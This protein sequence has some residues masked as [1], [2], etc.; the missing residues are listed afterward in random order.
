MNGAEQFIL[1]NFDSD[2]PIFSSCLNLIVYSYNSLS[3]VKKYSRNEILATTENIRQKAAKNIELEDYLRN[4]LV[5][6]YISPN[7]HLFGL[8]FYIFQS[9]AEEFTQNIKTGVLD[10]KVCSPL[11]DGDIY[12]IFE[13]KRLNKK[14]LSKY[15]DEG[16]LRF[17]NNQYYSE[18]D[19]NIGGMIAF[20]EASSNDDIIP[21]SSAYDTISNLLTKHKSKIALSSELLKHNLSCLGHDEIESFEY[22]YKSTH[23]V[24]DATEHF[25]LF[26]IALNYNDIIEA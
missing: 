24:S 26:H 7:R 15:I 19:T 9:G 2:T 6:N 23:D 8:D 16:V 3:K 21:L 12:Y 1:N 22:V 13:C 18:S 14:L 20:L 10:I 4:D 5:E 11:W 17:T 25:Q